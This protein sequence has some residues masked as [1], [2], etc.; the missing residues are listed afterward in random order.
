M[1][2]NRILRIEDVVAKLGVSRSSLYAWAKAESFP[3][4]IKLGARAVG[5]KESTI[6]QWLEDR[7]EGCLPNR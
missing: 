3:R 4:P 2:E 6:D 7:S 5:W 1:N